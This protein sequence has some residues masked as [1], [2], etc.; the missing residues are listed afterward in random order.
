MKTNVEFWGRR[1]MIKKCLICG[2]EENT[3][4][5]VRQHV[6]KNKEPVNVPHVLGDKY[7]HRFLRNIKA[8]PFK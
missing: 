2:E 4:K 1:K 5:E 3:S 7:Y 8:F 6:S